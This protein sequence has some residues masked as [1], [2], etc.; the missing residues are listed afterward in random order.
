[1][2]NKRMY[3]IGA[4]LLVIAVFGVYTYIQAQHHETTDNAQLDG[5][6]TPVRAS[7]AGYVQEVRFTDNTHVAKGDTLVIIDNVD[8]QAKVAQAE[9]ALEN[10]RA[11]LSMAQAGSTTAGFNATAMQFSSQAVQNNIA[12]A[13]SRLRKAQKE[14]DRIQKMFND[15]AATQQQLD[16]AKAEE[17]TAQ[18]QSEMAQKQYEVSSKQ[19]S[20]ARSQLDVQASQ[21][22][23][24][25]ALV[26]QREAELRLAQSQLANT[27]IT[28]PYDGT[29]SKKSVEDEQ[30]IQIG[31]PVC[32]A[33]DNSHLW[34]TANFKE[35]QFEN[36]KIGE[37]ATITVDAYDLELNGTI[38]SFGGATGARFSLLPPD[39]ATG[40]F[41]KVTQRIPVRIKLDETATAHHEFLAPGMSTF[42]D[43]HI[44]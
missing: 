33:I 44:P 40:N 10:A 42:V 39:N 31:Q 1:M 21:I 15:G 37:K 19:A 3:I 8:Y 32:S 35:T 43:V 14:L 5:R 9:A 27:I 29:I 11:Q 34:V 16:A 24:A 23:L 18:A 41:V 38:E 4:V 13:G 6:I 2:K 28:A 30:Y 20:G 36:L 12:A 7:V 22:S 25:E 26:K 17:E